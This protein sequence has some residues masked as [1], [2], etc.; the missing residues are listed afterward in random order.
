[1]LQLDGYPRTHM[2][3]RGCCDRG[4]D[5]G[6]IYE[7]RGDY[8]GSACLCPSCNHLKQSPAHPSYQLSCIRAAYL[9]RSTHTHRCMKGG[10]D[11]VRYSSTSATVERAPLPRCANS[12]RSRPHQRVLT[13]LHNERSFR[14]LIS[15]PAVAPSG[16]LRTS[17]I[18]RS[19]CIRTR[20]HSRLKQA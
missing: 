1:M 10:C 3:A 4:R 9:A 14:Q 13:M 19:L 18:R 8:F 2:C 6:A 20:Q 17:C 7:H 11:H 5:S 15:H 16:G 12:S